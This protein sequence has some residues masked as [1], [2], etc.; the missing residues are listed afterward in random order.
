MACFCGVAATILACSESTPSTAP[1]DRSGTFYGSTTTSMEAGYG[2]AYLTLDAAGAPTELGLAITESALVTLPATSAE[3]TFT[4]PSEA[5]VTAYKHAV[6]NWVP[7]GHEPTPYLVPHLDVHFYMISAQARNAI[8]SA[9]PA[10]T[11]KL[12]LQPPANYLP[13]GY[14]MDMGMPRMGMHWLN[15][16]SPE[17]NGQPFTSTYLYG[18]YDGKITFVEPMVAK[19]FLDSKPSLVK[20]TVPL[21]QLGSTT[22]YQATGYSVVFDE[23]KHEYRIA[24]VDFVP[25]VATA[26]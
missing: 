23:P 5:S 19:S 6:V 2:R 26:P 7:A 12:A 1:I 16:A 4:L 20:R 25:V 14:V 24:L 15:P 13:A 18:S 21:P 17:L 3:Y 9:D 11:T 8:T 22:G 10:Y